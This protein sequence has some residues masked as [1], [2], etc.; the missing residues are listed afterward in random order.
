MK[1]FFLAEGWEYDRVW[2]TQGLWDIT[3]WRRKP[4][5]KRLKLGIVENGQVLWLYQ[6]EDTVL[7]VEVKPIPQEIKSSSTIGQVVIKRLI[8]SEE[9]IQYFLKAQAI[10]N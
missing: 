2:E 9:V 6:V 1:Y 10:I 3:V 8:D 5:I 7:M 4:D